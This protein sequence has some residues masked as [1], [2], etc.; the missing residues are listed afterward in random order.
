MPDNHELP[1]F[2]TF[3]ETDI[4]TFPLLSLCYV[5]WI[6]TLLYL[7]GIIISISRPT[8]VFYFFFLEGGGHVYFQNHNHHCSSNSCLIATL[9]ALFIF[10]AATGIAR[11]QS[12]FVQTEGDQFVLNGKIFKIKGANYYPRD[13][14]WAYLW[15]EWDWTQIKTEA[16]MM[17]NFGLNA[18]RILV[19]YR[20]GGWNGPD[21]PESRLRMLEDLVNLF[22][23]K[24]IRCVITLFDWETSF[25]ESGT[26]RYS[27]HVAYM[28][29]IVNRFKNSPYVLMWDVKN[30]PDHPANFGWCSVGKWDCNPDKRNQIASWLRRM[31]NAVRDVDPNH[32]VS[33]GMRWWE[34]LPDVIDAFDVAIF[35][36]YD[37]PIHQEITD[38]QNL[39]GD[40]PKPILVEEWGWP[41]HPYPCERDGQ[42]IYLYN[43]EYQL[44]VY[45]DQ[46]SAFVEYDIAG[47]LVWMAM[48]AD[49]YGDNPS[50]TFEDYFGL[51]R[52]DYT[53]KPA[54]EYYRNAF[55]AEQFPTQTDEDE[56]GIDSLI[57]NCP[58][59]YNPD[60]ADSDNDG[61]GDVCDRC[62]G[63]DDNK[64]SDG[65]TVAD[66]CDT[67][68]YVPNRSQEDTD[69][70]GRADACDNC[71]D[72]P[73][74][75]QLDY[76]GDFIGDAC[77]NCPFVYNPNQLDDDGDGIGNA[78]DD[79]NNGS[80]EDDSDNDDE[81]PDLDGD[82]IADLEDNCPHIS[83]PDQAD[84]DG[85]KIG[86]ACDNCPGVINTSQMDK[87]TDGV[88]DACDL[89]P[90]DANKVNPGVCGCNQADVDM[91][92]DEVV[93]CVDNCPGMS[94]PQQV[95]TDLDDVG[96][97]CDI[98]PGYDDRTDSDGDHHPDGCDNCPQTVNVNQI[99]SDNDGIGDA[100]DNCPQVANTDQADEDDDG[101]GNVC[102][103]DFGE[104]N[105]S[106]DPQERG[107][108][109]QDSDNEADD[110]SQEIVLP[111]I[112]GNGAGQM[113]AVGLMALVMLRF[114]SRRRMN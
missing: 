23:E 63:Y 62:P 45:Q 28:Y 73:N 110:D 16:R 74:A 31:A 55:F 104:D 47:G 106:E 67:C 18:V 34:N 5:I 112:C 108:D 15:N 56:D 87:D 61:F 57:D 111:P 58:S 2:P 32:P 46:L 69:G 17:D 70:D 21:V 3:Y 89:C 64:D 84:D 9:V 94:N 113:L 75:N 44:E 8:G 36:S 54:A 35:H 85:D 97:V 10:V 101:I 40:N 107:S 4:C 82:E 109:D 96:D 38:T 81:L 12:Y 114:V 86:N 52:Y 68:P 42:Y 24:G 7:F 95:D 99:D 65:D 43:E 71:P 60:Q 103:E 29:K 78:C 76:D 26:D 80:D 53:L 11:A 88:G 39:M 22:G 79:S 19:P 98:C 77:D 93:D 49:Q 51:W 30:E 72:L 6:V 102:D 14:M 33:A 48:D 59:D 41:S 25:A 100:C 92:E 91:D 105:E 90:N 13:H 50:H 1:A 83:N 20:N 27:D 66:G 37:W